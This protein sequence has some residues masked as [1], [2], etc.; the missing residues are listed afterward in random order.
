M[1]PN[2]LESILNSAN[3][4]SS[5]R[6]VKAIVP[7][8]V[9]GQCADMAPI[10]SLAKDHRIPVIEDGAQAIGAE[11]PG[12]PGIKRANGMGDMGVFSFYPTKNLGAFGDAGMIMT[13]RGDLA[14]KLKLLRVHGAKD[15][16]YHEF[17]GGNFRMDAIQAG[18]LRVKL[19]HLDEWIEKRMAKASAYDN[20]FVQS[21]LAENGFI[22]TPRA[23]YR[24]R[25][26]RHYH[27]YHQYVISARNRD[28]LQIFL[29][30]KGVA[31]VIF[32]PLALHLQ[33]CFSHFGYSLGDFPESEKATSEVLALPIY[34]ELSGDQQEY[35]VACIKKFY[36]IG[37]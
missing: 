22:R 25:G 8:H 5:Q 4:G 3:A 33:Q 30:E 16:Y 11:Y 20:L 19:K 1:D 18:V 2:K 36:D 26:V 13:D 29:R 28:K 12:L 6:K 10:L 27:T 32:Y 31:S 21:G 35:I 9:Y 7:V 14:E 15:R 17:V 37:G 23:V 34:P 24:N